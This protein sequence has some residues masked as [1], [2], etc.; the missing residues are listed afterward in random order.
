[1][2]WG[3]IAALIYALLEWHVVAPRGGWL[4]ILQSVSDRIDDWMDDATFGGYD[5]VPPQALRV[6]AFRHPSHWI[7]VTGHLEYRGS[8]DSGFTIQRTITH[9]PALAGQGVI[10]RHPS[11]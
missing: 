9:A 2:I 8:I 3:A 7:D 4:G 6:G 5:P 10:Y 1:M 11:L